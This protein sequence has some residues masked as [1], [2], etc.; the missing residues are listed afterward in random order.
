[1]RP[2]VAGD[3]PAPRR[4]FLSR[5]WLIWAA[6]LALGVA[7][8]VLIA[9]LHASS[10]SSTRLPSN[11]PAAPDATWT[12]GAKPAPDFSLTDQAGQPVSI[13]AFRGRP[14]ILTFID[15]LCRNL[16]PLEAKVLD[17]VVSR[18][19]A[20]SRPAIVAVSVDQW[21]N[22]RRY[23]L[24]DV[25]RW[26]LPA[27]WHWAVGSP[28]ALKK[29]WADYQVAVQDAP[30]KVAGVLVHNISHTEAA[31]FVDPRGYQRALYLWPFRAPDV[32]RTIRQLAGAAG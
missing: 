9:V 1:M 30:K 21:G 15:P 14:V 32:E 13:A 10:P 19:P 4:R 2:S 24:E 5:T 16:C 3:V 12:A 8:G 17:A 26:K 28:A 27:Q 20:S 25:R 22:K 23:L 11:M 7:G 31:F 29:V 18:L 6:A